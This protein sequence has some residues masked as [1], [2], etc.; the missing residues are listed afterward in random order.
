MAAPSLCS[1]AI[2]LRSAFDAASAIRGVIRR[3]SSTSSLIGFLRRCRQGRSFFLSDRGGFAGRGPAGNTLPRDFA[4]RIR[5]RDAR[6]IICF[7]DP[8]RA[9]QPPHLIIVKPLHVGLRIW[10][11]RR[12]RIS[13]Q[14][15]FQSRVGCRARKQPEN[16]QRQQDGRRQQEPSTDPDQA[17]ADIGR[18]MSR[19]FEASIR[20]RV[21]PGL[22]STR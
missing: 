11:K 2:P 21:A 1:Y 20:H 3:M 18:F 9:V 5:N 16:D 15:Q 6:D 17:G 12:T 8:A 10:L 13:R 19:G 14:W 4:H 7:V 22:G